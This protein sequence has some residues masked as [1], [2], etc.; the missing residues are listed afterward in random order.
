MSEREKYPCFSSGARA[1]VNIY[2][3]FYC[4]PNLLL[5]WKHFLITLWKIQL[6]CNLG[7]L[8]WGFFGMAAL[9]G[10]LIRR[11][12]GE[13][14]AEELHWGWVSMEEPGFKNVGKT[15]ASLGNSGFPWEWGS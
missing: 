4:N 6:K 8:L 2:G 7:V 14:G 3:I 5:D 10:M 12:G 1:D 11:S 15:A 13:A 9:P